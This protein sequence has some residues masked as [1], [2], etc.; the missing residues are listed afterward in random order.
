[1][2]IIDAILNFFVQLIKQRQQTIES[3]AR[4][5]LMSAQARVKSK[6]AAKF[7]NAIDG[8][9]KKGRSAVTRKKK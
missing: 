2:N 5:K 1:M 7:N 4:G 9:V 8:S 3:R 6:A